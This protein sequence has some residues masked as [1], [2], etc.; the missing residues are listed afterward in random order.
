MPAACAPLPCPPPAPQVLSLQP[1][2]MPLRLVLVGSAGV[3]KTTLANR[4]VAQLAASPDTLRA[5]L[6]TALHGDLGPEQLPGPHTTVDNALRLFEGEPPSQGDDAVSAQDAPPARFSVTCKPLAPASGRAL[7][8]LRMATAAAAEVGDPRFQE[9]GVYD[10]FD[11]DRHG[12]AGAVRQRLTRSWDEQSCGRQVGNKYNLKRPR[13]RGCEYGCF[14]PTGQDTHC[15]HRTQHVVMEVPEEAEGAAF[16]FRLRW[17]SREVVNWQ[18]HQVGGAWG[19]VGGWGGRR[20]TERLGRV[21][22]LGP[23]GRVVLGAPGGQRARVGGTGE[24]RG[25]RACAP[26]YSGY[27][28]KPIR[29]VLGGLG[30]NG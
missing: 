22:E 19:R 16:R 13:V 11:L 4:T 2:R 9:G 28:A 7:N 18:V 24:E 23:P 12:V 30:N 8:D 20:S 26:P 17:A 6:P 14:L 10:Y 1:S 5:L 21:E 15:T 27:A 3:G 29:C 25:I